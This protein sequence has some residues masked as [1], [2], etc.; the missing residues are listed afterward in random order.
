MIAIVTP[1]FNDWKSFAILVRDLNEVARGIGAPVKIIAVDDGSTLPHTAVEI[2]PHPS[3]EGIDLI[4][5]NCNL[6][7]QRAISIGISECLRRETFSKILVMDSDG[8]DAPA[9]ILRM[10]AVSDERPRSIIVASRARRS[11]GVL[12]RIFYA[13]YKRA[14]RLM[15]GEFIDFGNFCLMPIEAAQRIAY[16]SESWNHFAASI[17]KSRVPLERIPTHRAKRYAGRS[18]MN[19]VSLVMHGFSA[20]SV[21]SDR[22]LTRLLLLTISTLV[23]AVVSGLS[24][25]LIRLSTNMAIPG[26]ATNV[27]GW[28]C[29]LFF[30]AITLLVVIIFTN[31]NSRSNIPFVP[32]V[33]SSQFVARTTELSNY[34]KT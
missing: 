11:E 7:H 10:L 6:G 22:V 32:G 18:S 14:F 23:V 20:I 1:I 8:E 3:I 21:F 26:W 5:L 9:D 28:S 15:T 30:Q 34:G 29:L 24:A 25:V 31:M 17:V 2:P 33:H 27:F 12:F 13:V 4:T 16:T 19:L